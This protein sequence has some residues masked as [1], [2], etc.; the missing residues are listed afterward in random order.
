MLMLYSK[1]AAPLS[2]PN[3]ESATILETSYSALP[4]K[5]SNVNLN[6]QLNKQLQ[7][8]ELA[9]K[10]RTRVLPTLLTKK[11]EIKFSINKLKT[12]QLDLFIYILFYSKR[13]SCY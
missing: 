13:S 10:Q 1:I 5:A 12:K 8:E 9:K 7:K 6:K 3:K 2:V 4:Y 11:E